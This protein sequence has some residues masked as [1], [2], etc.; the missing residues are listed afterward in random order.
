MKTK[1][2]DSPNFAVCLAFQCGLTKAELMRLVQCIFCVE[3]NK[4]LEDQDATGIV[5]V[6]APFLY[7][8]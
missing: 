7:F 5:P 3:E 1:Q 4:T 2:A 6:K 8:C